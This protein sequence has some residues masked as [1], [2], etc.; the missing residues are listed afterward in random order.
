MKTIACIAALVVSSSSAFSQMSEN[1][2][3]KIIKQINTLT[4]DY[5][6]TLV[7]P[8]NGKEA[9]LVVSMKALQTEKTRKFWT[10][11]VAAA[12]GKY[13]ND[14]PDLS[15]KEIR[16]S[17]IQEMKERPVKYAVL[18]VSIAKEVQSKIHA[19]EMEFQDGMD[20]IWRSLVRKTQEIK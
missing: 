4:S 5:T 13:F 2:A 6:E 15:V 12:I 19:G 10:F 14:N 7:T 17:D 1:A 3:S 18:E 8:T 20:K 9:V 11:V 16:L